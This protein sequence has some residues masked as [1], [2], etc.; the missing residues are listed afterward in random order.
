M[1]GRTGEISVFLSCAAESSVR[2]RGPDARK[3]TFIAERV[4]PARSTANYSPPRCRQPA[5]VA[6]KQEEQSQRRQTAVGRWVGTEKYRCVWAARLKNDGQTRVLGYKYAGTGTY[7]YC[8]IP[9][10]FTRAEPTPCCTYVHAR[11]HVSSWLQTF[12]LALSTPHTNPH[13]TLW[14]VEDLSLLGVIYSVGCEILY[15]RTGCTRFWLSRE[16]AVAV[17]EVHVVI[18]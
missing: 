12:S 3:T 9:Q 16:R 7:T 4:A 15:R 13:P 2:C 18:R 14:Y 1:D 10:F 17:N 8:M 6:V 5:A 11:S